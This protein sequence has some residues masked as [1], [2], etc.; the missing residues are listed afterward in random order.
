MAPDGRVDPVRHGEE[1]AD[2]PAAH[3]IDVAAVRL[4]MVHHDVAQVIPGSL[5]PLQT[6]E[7]AAAQAPRFPLPVTDQ[8][9]RDALRHVCGRPVCQHETCDR[10]Q[11]EARPVAVQ[12]GIA[13][14]ERADRSRATDLDLAAAAPRDVSPE[15]FD[16]SDELL[17]ITI[18]FG[19][20]L[21]RFPT[22][23][24]SSE[25]RPGFAAAADVVNSSQTPSK[26]TM[27]HTLGHFIPI[28]LEHAIP[29]YNIGHGFMQQ[30]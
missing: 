23:L 8:P 2:G 10:P 28:T 13:V 7:R 5:H 3:G 15:L 29:R 1:A 26:D 14:V 25:A 4:A 21:D 6:M 19:E 17:S 11:I 18:C 30:Q 20:L 16:K 24:P 27:V 9:K 22:A 12:G